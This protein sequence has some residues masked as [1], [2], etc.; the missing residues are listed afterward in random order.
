M[1]L[2]PLRSPFLGISLIA[3]VLAPLSGAETVFNADF[4]SVADGSS[5][6]GFTIKNGGA[7]ELFVSGGELRA[8]R[9]SAHLL[10]V[11]ANPSL[12]S[13]ADYTVSTRLR[14]GRGTDFWGGVVARISNEGSFYHARVFALK[15]DQAEF[16]LYRV[17]GPGTVL[18]GKT[19]FNYRF[20]VSYV[21]EL[22]VKG[23][24]QEAR[25]S[26]A[27][28]TRLAV[29]SAEDRAFSAGS[30]GLRA[31]PRN[32]VVVFEEFVVETTK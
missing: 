26:D 10:A 8:T 6:P 30:A 5:P 9:S 7:R 27:H 17:G 14:F 3:C 15:D 29:L 4:K 25:L 32:S 11:P 31:Y 23:S 13:L 19:E 18:L 16:Q 24:T 22:T 1:I 28:G 2:R 20:G 21:V 12:A